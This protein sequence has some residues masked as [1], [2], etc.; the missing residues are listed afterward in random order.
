MTLFLDLR[1]PTSGFAVAEQVSITE[2]EIDPATGNI[3]ASQSVSVTDISRAVLGKHL[4]FAAHGFNVSW[5]DGQQKLSNWGSLLQL[6]DSWLFMGILWPGNSSWLGPLCYPGE[7]RHAVQSGDLLAHFIAENLLGC[8]SVSFISHSLGA[9]QILQT[10][11]T[12]RQLAPSAPVRHAI[13]MAGAVNHDALTNEYADA[14]EAIENI[15]LLTS[16]E[17]EVLAAAFPIGNVFE[18]IID[19]GHPWFQSALGRSGPKTIPPGKNIPGYQVPDNWK[20]GHGSYL[21]ITPPAVPP[22]ALPQDLPPP[23][24]YA[25][26]GRESVW[27]AAYASSR[28]R[29][30]L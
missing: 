28:L 8:A 2:V 7:G 25:P 29:G 18:G 21:N 27:T 22:L 11:T 4:V 6:D 17:D 23:A 3:T 12:L 13:L 14:A 24:G 9:R 15:A 26:T 30:L 16:L 1:Q 5:L 20:F 10:V 19:A